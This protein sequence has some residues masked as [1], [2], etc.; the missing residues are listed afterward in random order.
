MVAFS[1]ASCM[2]RILVIEDDEDNRLLFSEY[3]TCAGF[4]VLALAD[5]LS[6]NSHLQMFQ[7]DLLLLDLGL[8]VVDGYSVLEAIHSYSHWQAIP[9]IV[10]SG[11]A[12]LANQRR[13]LALG[14]YKYLVKPVRPD[15]LVRTVQAALDQARLSR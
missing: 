3:L 1:P 11:Y 5:H 7:P 12:F 2:P 13:A 4:T 9:V 6:L 15:D 10:I 14:A 8:P